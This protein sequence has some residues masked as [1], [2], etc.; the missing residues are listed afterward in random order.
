MVG[1]TPRIFAGLA[2][3]SAQ[4][5]PKR[6]GKREGRH[7]ATP[8]RR[9]GRGQGRRG[10]AAKP[11]RKAGP[12]ERP[13]P[14]SWL[15]TV[16]STRRPGRARAE[17]MP[18]HVAWRNAPAGFTKKHSRCLI[19]IGRGRAKSPSAGKNRLF[20]E[21]GRPGE[22]RTKMSEARLCKV[23]QDKVHYL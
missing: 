5:R 8:S 12:I 15:R 4:G 9:T 2:K 10:R 14:A 18:Y 13:A 21:G 19:K 3:P 20:L 7:R 6:T 22:V 1:I 16:T 11:G 23:S 17:T